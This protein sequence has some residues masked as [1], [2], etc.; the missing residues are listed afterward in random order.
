MQVCKQRPTPSIVSDIIEHLASTCPH[1]KYVCVCVCVCVRVDLFWNTTVV[2]QTR[3]TCPKL[4]CLNFFSALLVW[5]S[6]CCLVRTGVSFEAKTLYLHETN[7][8]LSPRKII[9]KHLRYPS[10][11]ENPFP[12]DFDFDFDF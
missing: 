7:Q 9:K 10:F 3:T 6:K 5:L 8:N 2:C 12:F 11:L 1:S 4:L